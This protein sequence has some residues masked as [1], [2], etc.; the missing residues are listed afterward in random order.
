MAM[1]RCL[2]TSTTLMRRCSM[3]VFVPEMPHPDGKA[4]FPV[5]Y[6][7]HGRSGDENSYRD[8]GLRAIA[9]KYHFIVVTA[10]AARS[11]YCD[12]VSGEKYWTFFT[13]ELPRLMSVMYPVR[14][15]RSQTFAAGISMGGYGAL[16]MALNFP[17][18]FSK[19]AVLS[20]AADISWLSSSTGGMSD[21]ELSSIFGSPTGMIGNEHDL[22]ELLKRPV[23]ACGRPE[24]MM[25]CGD[26]D[27]LIEGNREFVKRAAAANWQTD[28]QEIPGKIHNWDCWTPLMPEIFEFFSK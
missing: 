17:E 8:H 24:L 18:R 1:M 25:R 27:M 3:N 14:T 26:A 20:A 28:Y 13:V 23:P 10:D 6:L 9:E 15:E 11:F 19:V 21:L 4:G 22:F 12:M 5:I 2:F 7:L 16:K